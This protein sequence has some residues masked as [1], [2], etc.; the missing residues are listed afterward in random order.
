VLDHGASGDVGEGFSREAS[1]LVPRWNDRD[2]RGVHGKSY[3]TGGLTVVR[4]IDRNSPRIRARRS[5][6]S[7][8]AAV[9]GVGGLLLVACLAAANMPQGGDA[10]PARAPRQRP[11]APDALAVEVSSQATRLRSLMSQAPVP[12]QNSRNPFSFAARAPRAVAPIA[13]AAVAEEAAPLPP[14][15]PA[16]T[17]MGVAEE[18]T[19]AGPRRTAVIGGDG[20]TIYMVVEGEPVGTRYRVTKIG[21]DAVELEDV[22]TKA[23][24]RL[25]LR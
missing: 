25:A 12:D 3:H 5:M 16:L 17:L 14:P 10:F 24:R 2:Y 20:D 4:C 22:V 18:T 11:A 7:R 19:A 9:Y 1:R 21:A 13:H 8:S 6:T 23:Y 15:L